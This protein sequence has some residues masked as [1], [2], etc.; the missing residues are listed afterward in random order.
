MIVIFSNFSRRGCRTRGFGYFS[1][2]SRVGF[3][4]SGMSAVKLK[5]ELPAVASLKQLAKE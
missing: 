3:P 1:H 5:T 2:E 4:I